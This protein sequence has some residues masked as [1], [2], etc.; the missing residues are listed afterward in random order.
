[1]RECPRDGFPVVQINGR[2]ECVAE[3]IDRCIGG[4]TVADLVRKDGVMHYIFTNGHQ[5]PL[6]CFCC[7]EPLAVE[8]LAQ[9]RKEIVGL[10]LDSMSVTM[11]E[12]EDGRELPQFTLLLGQQVTADLWEA[13]VSVSPQVA[14]QMS[15]PSDCRPGNKRRVRKPKPRRG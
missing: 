5:L 3:Y 15:H 9:A 2:W 13:V 6:L 12:L 14:A 8:D 10:H 11:V 7:D 4:Q 1:M